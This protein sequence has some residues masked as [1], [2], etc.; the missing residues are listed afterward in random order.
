M[1][2]KKTPTA[3]CSF[4]HFISSI[5]A[6]ISRSGK[7]TTHLSRSGALAQAIGDE[8]I[9]SP[10]K[11]DFQS[12]VV[13]QIDQKQRWI[14]DL[15]LDTDLVHVFQARGGIGDFPHRKMDIAPAGFF[16]LRR[17][18]DQ[19]EA[20]L[21]RGLRK[22]LAVDQPKCIA[23]PVPG[24]LRNRPTPACAGTFPYRYN[25]TSPRT[26]RYE[27]RH[28]QHRPFLSLLIHLNLSKNPLFL[29][30]SRTLPSNSRRLSGVC[31]LAL[32][33]VRATCEI[34]NSSPLRSGRTITPSP[35]LAR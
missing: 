31:P 34:I 27:Y 17:R 11:R 9:I 13:G 12:A 10:A 6:S 18:R 28:R 19:T 2:R 30:S 24:I 14:N 21:A 5:D 23:L 26:R 7:M 1:P 29:I 8:P 4:A 22:N 16:L 20:R 32:A 35:Y 3:P 25:S 15:D 33:F